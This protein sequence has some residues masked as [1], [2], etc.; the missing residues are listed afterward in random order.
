MWLIA[1]LAGLAAVATGLLPLH[2][3]AA[4]TGRVAPVLAFLAGITVLAELADAAEVFDIAA[5]W[6]A[7]RAA[8][9]GS[10]SGRQ[11]LLLVAVL[12]T[13]TT[14][15]LS[16]DT[17]AVLLTPVVL[18]LAESLGLAPLPFALAAVWLA[19][20]ASLLLPVSNL[21]NLLAVNRLQV[22]ALGFAARMG[23]PEL[24]AVTLTVAFIAVRF[25]RELATRYAPPPPQPPLDRTLYLASCL[26]CLAIGPGV[27]AG[28]PPYAIAVPAAALLAGLFAVRQRAV[29]R[30]SLLPWRLIVLTEG[31]FLVVTAAGI[32][33]L[34]HLLADAAGQGGGPLTVLRTAGVGAAAS[35]AVNN[36]PAYLAIER[37][38]PLGHHDQ[39]FGLLLGT[40]AGPLVLLY[41]SLATLL[42]RERCR[43]RGLEVSALQFARLGLPLVPVL[44]LGSW[45]A[46]EVTR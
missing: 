33:G 42:W 12:G 28:V 10:G 6:T 1:A 19:N 37:A 23:L 17:T 34:D 7:R 4:V 13:A 45:L 30:W 8:P 36:L 21:T 46:L 16:L 32:H 40:N 35:N 26:A 18:S 38:V 3:A 39:L 11:L 41:G 25:R 22:S 14:V 24:V 29:L 31:L 44:L 5:R 2:D 9:R 43:A 27:L 20:T 15:L